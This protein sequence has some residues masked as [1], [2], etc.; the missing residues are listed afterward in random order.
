ML[1][2]IDG[3]NFI[4]K[5]TRLE[6]AVESFGL[7]RGRTQ[8]LSLLASYKLLTGQDFTVVFDG[9]EQQ[10]F[11]LSTQ[12]EQ[13]FQGIKV[14]FSKTTTAD[15][16]IIS[17]IQLFPNPKEITVVSSDNAVKRAASRLGCHT[18][19]PEDFYKK[20]RRTLKREKFSPT[21]EPTGKYQE[22]SEHDI[23]YWLKFFQEKPEGER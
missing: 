4:F 3:Y 17:L 2:I 9:R 19:P 10:D 6:E 11:P 20:I 7:E 16:D 8:L 1:N 12:T 23:K 5:I 14:V 15:E 22:L 13:Y 21:K 18:N